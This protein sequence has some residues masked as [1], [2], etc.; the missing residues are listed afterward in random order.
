ME[1]HI[2]FSEV[3][4]LKY[5]IAGCLWNSEDGGRSKFCVLLW[6]ISSKSV[7]YFNMIL[8]PLVNYQFREENLVK[9]K[10]MTS[11]ICCSVNIC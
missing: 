11:S 4:Q 5:G 7:T 9:R 8:H 2:F 1:M 10:Q 3:G 6:C